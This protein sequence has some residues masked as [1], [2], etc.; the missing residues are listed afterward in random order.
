MVRPLTEHPTGEAVHEG[1]GPEASPSVSPS[2]LHLIDQ[3]DQLAARVQHVV[4]CRRQADPEPDDPFRGL[5]LSD[6]YIDWLLA[7]RK[8]ESSYPERAQWSVKAAGETIGDDERSPED[9][10]LNLLMRRFGLSQFEREILLIALA[11]DIESRYEQFYGYLNDDVSRRRATIGMALELSGRSPLD[12]VARSTF[13]QGAPLIHHRLMSIE[14]EHRPF[15]SQA[16]RV[17]E[18]IVSYLLGGDRP[19]VLLFDLIRPADA[20]QE[21]ADGSQVARGLS[22]GATV[23]YLR[24]QAGGLALSSAVAG[25]TQHGLGSMMLDLK[26]A[27]ERDG[28]SELVLLAHREALLQGVGLVASPVEALVREAPDC[29]RALAQLTGPIVLVGETEWDPSWCEVVPYALESTQPTQDDRVQIWQQALLARDEDEPALALE[30]AHL[31]LNPEAVRRSVVAAQYR[32][33]GEAVPVGVAHLLAGARSQNG[34]G[35]KRLARHINPMMGW[36]DLVVADTVEAQ[37]RD[38]VARVRHRSQVLD[39]W[40]MRPGG[41]RGRGITSLFAGDP[42]TGKTMAAEVIAQ[43]L[44]LDLYAIDLSTVVDKYIGETEKNLERIFTEAEGINAVILFDEADALFGKRSEVSDAHDRHANVEVAYLL[45]RMESFDGLAVLATNL[46]A[47]IDEAFSRRLDVVVDFPMPDVR[48]R[49]I[50][51][52]QCLGARVP[53][54]SDLDLEFC[55]QSFV[56]SGGS[57]RSIA[58]SAAYAAAAAGCPVS[59]DLLTQAIQQEYRKLGRL[60]VVGEFGPWHP[61]AP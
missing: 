46:R 32:A 12:D 13:L 4:G 57:I 16:L 2:M 43:D 38:V 53:R 30:L 29:I 28:V 55:A 23:V 60:I 36:N 49:R 52:D 40:R 17:P 24:D 9:S 34:A 5:A 11:P 22:S 42:G 25:F 47:N 18:R 27:V 26:R 8:H 20:G 3:L 21:V 15:L 44:G 61:D 41:G 7:K 54:S 48:E 56:L 59:M 6:R 33:T 10:R 45:Q 51:W 50:L 14:D 58:L 37:L 31:N 1:F 19:D 35:L 39:D